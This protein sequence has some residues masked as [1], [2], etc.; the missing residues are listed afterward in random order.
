MP[1]PRLPA[2]AAYLHLNNPTRRNAL[3]L[4]VLRDLHSQL[5]TL[6][7]SPKTGRLLL[8]PPFH[9]SVLD[10]LE[11]G[12][13]NLTWLTDSSQ[14]AQERANLPNVIVLRSEGPVFSSGH[15]LKA[16]AGASHDEVKETCYSSLSY[17]GDGHSSGIPASHDHG[18]SHRVGWHEVLS[19]RYGN[20]SSLY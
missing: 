13:T 7:T 1:L 8:L 15:D 4:P 5:T 17:P 11:S 10:Q 9:P 18:F 3:S 2:K 20:W 6:L 19:S 14:W 12:N 16:L